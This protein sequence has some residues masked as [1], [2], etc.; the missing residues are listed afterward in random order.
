MTGGGRGNEN[1]G[2]TA[3]HTVFHA[4]HN[5]LVQ[6]TKDVAL[7]EAQSNGE[8]DFLNEWLL[9]PVGSLADIDTQAERDAL[10]WDGDHD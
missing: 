1:I 5:R 3:V 10:Q 4:E 6:H 8:I 7:A 9:V 2:L